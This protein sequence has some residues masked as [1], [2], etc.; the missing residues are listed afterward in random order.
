MKIVAVVVVQ[1]VVVG[2][3][4]LLTYGGKACLEPKRIASLSLVS[5]CAELLN[6]VVCIYN[7]QIRSTANTF[8]SGLLPRLKGPYKH[9]VSPP[10]S[11]PFFLTF[12]LTHSN[13]LQYPQIPRQTNRRDKIPRQLILARTARR[14]RHLP[15]Q[16]RPLRR[17]RTHK[18]PRHSRFHAK[19]LSLTSLS[20]GIS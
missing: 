17:P 12:P 7:T 19:G 3:S 10:P 4:F 13:S 18:T 14:R 5:T 9:P 2:E 11:H 6:T 20:C 15:H 1:A 8:F 16:R